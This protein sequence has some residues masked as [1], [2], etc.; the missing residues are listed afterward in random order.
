MRYII[1]GDNIDIT[2]H[3][4]IKTNNLQKVDCQEHSIKEI[5]E[6]I[7]Q[8]NLFS[9]NQFFFLKNFEKLL[10]ENN[11]KRIIELLEKSKHSNIIIHLQSNLSS[12][13]EEK[14]QNYIKNNFKVV[15]ISKL[16]TSD[17]TIDD[18]ISLISK[19]HGIEENN[20]IKENIKNILKKTNNDFII[21]ER[22]IDD[23]I[24]LNQNKIMELNEEI[25]DF[26]ISQ[27]KSI[28]FFNVV[29]IFLE[30]LFENK[31]EN[32]ENLKKITTKY[33]LFLNYLDDIELNDRLEELWGLIFSQLTAIIKIYNEYLRVGENSRI[34]ATNLKINPYRVSMLMK[35]VRK[36]D[37]LVKYN[38]YSPTHLISSFLESEIKIKT[39]KSN[40]KQEII[41]LLEFYL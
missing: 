26:F 18:F 38:G 11:F 31:I 23:I 30:I 28:N 4:P 22:I 8:Q 21:A 3:I 35:F 40:Y 29:N 6:I 27:Y 19:K 14:L 7:V 16:E 34:I 1:I 5:E 41:N 36:L 24:F 32:L 9:K 10:E 2:K 39:N 25:I 12:L 33:E 17:K 37:Y 13:K 15:D 20:S